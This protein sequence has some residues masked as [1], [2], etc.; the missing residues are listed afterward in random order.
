MV[1]GVDGAE[2]ASG[3][4]S[5]ASSGKADGAAATD[6]YPG[7]EVAGSSKIL[8]EGGRVSSSTASRVSNGN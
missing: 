6:G 3:S 2:A 1:D 4:R 8:L 5:L 7:S